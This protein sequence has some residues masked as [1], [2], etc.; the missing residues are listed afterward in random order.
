MGRT[1]P[2][3]RMQV[4]STADRWQPYRRGLR[5]PDKPHFDRLFEH[6]RTHADAGGHVNATDPMV[7]ILVSML[8][9][10]ERELARLSHQIAD[11]AAAAPEAE[12][13]GEDGPG[14]E[15]GGEA[16]GGDGD[17]DADGKDVPAYDTSEAT[18]RHRP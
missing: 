11:D 10:H 5:A 2:T 9:A 8:L 3:Y 4:E 12:A 14:N 13:E 7:P 1:N 18:P 17:G 6:A 16:E 15:T